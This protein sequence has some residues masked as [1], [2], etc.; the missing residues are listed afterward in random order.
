MSA[1]SSGKTA[2]VYHPRYLEHRPGRGHPERPERLTAIVDR[3]R[4][5]ATLENLRWITP[6]P[7]DRPS[8]ETVHEARYVRHVQDVAARAP[9][10]LDAGDTPV[11]KESYDVAC[12]AAGGVI[13]A[14]DEVMAGRLRNAFCAVR[15]PG[16]HARPAAAMGFC[17]FNNVAIGARHVQRKHGVK[18]VLIV[19]WDVHHGNGTQEA[20]YD[21]PSVLFFS[22]HQFP[23]YP[24]PSGAAQNTGRGP[25]RGFNI[26]VP[27]PAGTD[28]KTV[29]RHFL[30]TL[31]PAADKFAPQCV[32]I[33]CGFDAHKDDQLGGLRMTSAGFGELTRIVCGIAERHGNGRLVSVLEG[34]Y[35]LEAIAESAVHHVQAL[36]ASAAPGAKRA[37][38][39]SR[40]IPP[41]E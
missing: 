37:A 25:G 36:V 28:E 34:G 27:L 6:T 21:D 16:H 8:I 38:D 23:F 19:D 13:G 15:P 39:A 20:F 41:S 11:S 2:V 30:D 24:G 14:I 1:Q 31:V 4:A 40:R 12:L 22:V 29:R 32:L 3:L 9:A 26:N 17:L 18:R 5:E 35:T 7:A 33:S 10:L